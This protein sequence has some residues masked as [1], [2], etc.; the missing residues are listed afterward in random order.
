MYHS[1]E[2]DETGRCDPNIDGCRY[3][4][5]VLNKDKDTCI[6][7]DRCEMFPDS[8]ECLNKESHCNLHPDSDYCN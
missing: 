4:Y 3:D 7:K 5:L 2:D 8:R 1:T 6:E